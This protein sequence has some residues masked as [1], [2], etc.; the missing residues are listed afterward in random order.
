MFSLFK[1]NMIVRCTRNNTNATTALTRRPLIRILSSSSKAHS[2]F[3]RSTN[4]SLKSTSGTNRT[5]FKSTTSTRIFNK[6]NDT[7]HQIRLA[8][9]KLEEH[10]DNVITANHGIKIIEHV[11]RDENNIN[12]KIS[13]RK[14]FMEATISIPTTIN[15]ESS[16]HNSLIPM[17]KMTP[18]P[19]ME[20]INEETLSANSFNKKDDIEL[21]TYALVTTSN[22]TFSQTGIRETSDQETAQIQIET[23]VT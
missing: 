10:G 6:N 7:L 8:K 2:R 14:E 3:S 5:S 19:S 15:E 18:T 11:V 23:Y 1:E 13:H 12:D 4:N 9:Q 20:A 21:L 16:R 17:V 22:I